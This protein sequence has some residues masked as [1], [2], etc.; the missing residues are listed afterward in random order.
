[1]EKEQYIR[2]RLRWAGENLE[3]PLP[4]IIVGEYPLRSGEVAPEKVMFR[5]KGLVEMDM[6][7]PFGEERAKRLQ[8]KIDATPVEER[9]GRWDT[10]L[11]IL[12]KRRVRHVQLERPD[13]KVEGGEVEERFNVR[14]GRG[15]DTIVPGYG[16]EG[17][18][19]LTQ[20]LS[21]LE[22]DCMLVLDNKLEEVLGQ[23]PSSR[24][25]GESEGGEDVGSP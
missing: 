11:A 15:S 4:S 1:M 2:D 9:G 16:I 13:G 21:E 18:P 12:R 20:T 8:K 17:L 7:D 10:A 6:R 22:G 14:M 24:A 25:E 5:G 23:S 19:Q 3:E